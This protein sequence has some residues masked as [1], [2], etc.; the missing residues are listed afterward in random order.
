VQ[1][2][3]RAQQEDQLWNCFLAAL[4]PIVEYEAEI[5]AE[6]EEQEYDND[7]DDE[8]NHAGDGDTYEGYADFSGDD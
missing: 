7:S 8:N 6:E 4:S 2:V 5:A 1:A 3:I